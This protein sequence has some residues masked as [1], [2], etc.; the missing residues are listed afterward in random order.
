MA[1]PCGISTTDT[2]NTIRA[3]FLSSIN[4]KSPETVK[5]DIIAALIS[6]MGFS[7]SE[8]NKISNLYY[9]EYKDNLKSNPPAELSSMDKVLKKS[10]QEYLNFEADA[11]LLSD[12]EIEFIKKEYDRA[13]NFRSVGSVTKA[14]EIESNVSTLLLSKMKDVAKTKVFEGFLY[15]KP[16]ISFRF[17]YSSFVSNWIENLIRVTT[18]AFANKGGINLKELTSIFGSKYGFLKA[19]NVLQGGVTAMDTATTENNNTTNARPEKLRLGGLSSAYATVSEFAKKVIDVPDTL[20]I[21]TGTDLHYRTLI[22]NKKY[23]ELIAAGL[24]KSDAKIAA[25]TYASQQMVLMNDADAMIVADKVFTDNAIA[26]DNLFRK[27]NEYKIAVEEIKRSRRDEEVTQRAFLKSSEDY[28]KSKMTQTSELGAAY[29]GIFGLFARGINVIKTQL[30]QSAEEAAKGGNVNTSKFKTAMGLQLFGFL[31]GASAFAEKGIEAVPIYGLLKIAALQVSGKKLNEELRTEIGQKQRDIAMR[32]SVGLVMYGLLRGIKALKED[33]CE[34]ADIKVP[35]S[36]IYGK[37]RTTICGKQVSPFIIPP[38]FEAAFGFYNWLF[39][40]GIDEKKDSAL[41]DAVGAVMGLLSNAR[42]GADQPSVKMVDNLIE[43]AAQSKRGNELAAAE[44]YSKAINNGMGI[45]VNF[46]NSFLP[47]PTRPIQ[48]IGSYLSPIQRQP[49]PIYDIKDPEN[50]IKTIGNAAKYN[51][52]NLAGITSYIEFFGTPNKPMLDWQGRTV[53]NLRAG[54][55]VGEGIQYNK[56][57]DLFAQSNAPLPYLSPYREILSGKSEIQK[58]KDP[59][60]TKGELL[61][62]QPKRY[63]SEDEF[64]EVQK[65]AANFNANFFKKNADDYFKM[66][67]VERERKLTGYSNRLSKKVFEALDKGVKPNKIESYLYMN[68]VSRKK[69]SATDS[70]ID[71]TEK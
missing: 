42:V 50:V 29:N 55:F 63:L 40:T 67:K 16:L 44:S 8:A 30:T 68:M 59:L 5:K 41:Q 32:M 26:V 52:A 51:L 47:I 3:A 43:G 2:L 46:A 23:D 15:T 71:K 6:D 19:S 28:F 54:Y 10:A 17:T 58:S 9:S 31:N 56:Y 24:K 36:K 65:Q 27:S 48:E 57:D 25:R 64:Y 49:R 69:L 33:N 38:Q 11:P 18:S 45:A 62:F 37:Y 34:N 61:T 70:E 60:S 22:T 4:T 21:I 66:D 7:V 39:D 12:P 14:S 35:E 13:N 53:I 20:G 1:N